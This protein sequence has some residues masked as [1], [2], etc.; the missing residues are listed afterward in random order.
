[1]KNYVHPELEC[2]PVS[3][4]ADIV[5]VSIGDA[6]DAGGDLNFPKISL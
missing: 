2:I 1:M 4:L 5:T 6:G 3:N